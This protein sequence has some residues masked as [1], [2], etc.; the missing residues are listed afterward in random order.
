MRV[1]IDENVE[2]N[3][4]NDLLTESFNPSAEKVL[5][6][7]DYLDKN[8]KKGSI[9]DIDSNGY[10]QKTN[11]INMV[12]NGQVIK[13]IQPDEMLLLL[14]DKFS[15]IIQNKVDRKKFLKQVLIDWYT[16]NISKNGLL[17]VNTI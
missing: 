10:P 7:K 13:T 17:S 11:V 14:D 12:S 5:I 6:I 4:I 8:F 16:N 1:I 3:I 2:Q 15:K 9:E